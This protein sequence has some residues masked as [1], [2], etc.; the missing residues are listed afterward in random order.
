MT[1]G[2]TRFKVERLVRQVGNVAPKE[3]AKAGDLP[4]PADWLGLTLAEEAF[5]VAVAGKYLGATVTRHGWPDFLVQ[6]ADRTIGVEV[7]SGADSVSAAQAMTFKM[8]EQ[9]GIEVLVWDP[10]RPDVL[11][12]WRKRRLPK[13]KKRRKP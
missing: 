10:V 9:A 6:M 12:P 1:Y 3:R 4:S 13:R 8:L 2:G 5:L 7:K 11:T